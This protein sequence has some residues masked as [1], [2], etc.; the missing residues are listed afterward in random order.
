M[1]R[2]RLDALPA[3]VVA[4]PVGFIQM[5]G[6]TGADYRMHYQSVHLDILA[7]AM[8]LAGPVA[9]LARRRAPVAVL[10]T[11]M[12]VT[13]GYVLRGYV[14]GPVFLSMIVAIVAAVIRGRRTAVWAVTGGTVAVISAI[15]P[16]TPFGPFRLHV[17]SYGHA[18]GVLTWLLLVLTAAELLR[19][20]SERAA[21]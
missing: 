13:T 16:F 17:W 15:G 18:L 11:V 14:F 2:W 12:T 8:L 4:L 5:M 6:S 1:G 21:E 20:R 7:Y 19:I 10:I 9:L 3:F